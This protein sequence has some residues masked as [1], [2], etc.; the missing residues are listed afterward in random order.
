MFE[1]LGDVI[2]QSRSDNNRH[3]KYW[4][5]R[6]DFARTDAIKIIESSI[7]CVFTNFKDLFATIRQTLAV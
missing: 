2:N 5:K 7:I 6:N 3:K 1:S 4:E